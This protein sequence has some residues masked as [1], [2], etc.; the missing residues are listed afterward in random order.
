MKILQVIPFFSPLFGG[1]PVVPYNLSKALTKRGH[2]LTIFTSDYKV[3]QEWIDSSPNIEV[4]P[5]KMR[6][7]LKELLIT[8]S[9]WKFAKEGLKDF[10]VIHMH[11]Y[12]TFQNIVIHH[13]AMKYGIPY[14]LQSHGS[15]PRAMAKQRLKWIYDAFF[16]NSLL[17]DA[18][19]L[20]ALNQMEV[21]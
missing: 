2:N 5:F 15:L 12:R 4:F 20:I 8:P 11:N 19:K 21:E 6:M 3:S 14:V 1:S 7:N 13:Y 10:D 9:M 17:K 18:S 16:G